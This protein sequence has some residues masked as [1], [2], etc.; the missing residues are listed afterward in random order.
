VLHDTDVAIPEVLGSRDQFEAV[1]EVLIRG[2]FGWAD[3]REELH[4]ELQVRRF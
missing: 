2:S 1:A 4:T 3:R